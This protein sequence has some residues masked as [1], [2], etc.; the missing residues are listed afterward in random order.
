MLLIF[1]EKKKQTKKPER[2]RQ[3]DR[4]TNVKRERGGGGG[5]GRERER[6]RES[7]VDV[8]LK[9]HVASNTLLRLL[10]IAT[11]KLSLG[12][13][14]KQSCSKLAFGQSLVLRS[15]AAKLGVGGRLC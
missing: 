1:E 2:D 9:H 7:F 10:N 11:S 6:E 13:Y 3:R 15:P 8:G 12:H 5:G 4:Q 14:L